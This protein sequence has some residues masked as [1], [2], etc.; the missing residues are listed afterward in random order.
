MKAKHLF[1][2]LYKLWSHSRFC[3]ASSWTSRVE[4]SLTEGCSRRSLSGQ[5]E[6]PPKIEPD[7]VCALREGERRAPRGNRK[8]WILPERNTEE[9]VREPGL[10][11]SSSR[12]TGVV[13]PRSPMGS[14]S[15]RGRHSV[16]ARVLKD[17][18]ERQR[19][20]RREETWERAQRHPECRLH[21]TGQWLSF[22]FFN[23]F[24]VLVCFC[25]SFPFLFFMRYIIS[26]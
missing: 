9:L 21:P 14:K 3:F 1:Y 12:E 18:E 26:F 23:F 24:I 4:G 11:G 25:F 2:I 20:K 5:R 16:R 17:G 19:W 7:V 6:R 8:C 15:P 13:T 10:P 22:L